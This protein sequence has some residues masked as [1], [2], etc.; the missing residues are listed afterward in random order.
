MRGKSNYSVV[1]RWF[2]QPVDAA[3]LGLFRLS[4]GGFMLLEALTRFPKVTGV[5]SPT[6]FH[7]KYPL[8]TWVQGFPEHWM[9]YAEIAV[10][11][12]AALGI[13]LGVFFRASSLLFGSIYFHLFLT[14]TVYYNNHFYLTSIVTVLL[15]FTGADKTFS[16]S[17]FRSRDGEGF[18]LPQTVPFWNYILIR[19]QFF[20]L[21]FFGGIAKLNADWIRAEPIKYWFQTSSSVRPPL[22]WVIREEWFA[23]MAAYGGIAI[24]LGAP[25][26]LLWRRTR[27][28]AIAVLVGFHLM[29]SRIFKIGFFPFLGIVAC[30]PFLHP[31]TGRWIWSKYQKFIAGVSRVRSPDLDAA[32]TNS[33]RSR[34]AFWMVASFL[35][36]QMIFPLRAYI[37]GQNPAWTEVGHKF[38]WRMML[39]NKD[40]YIKFKFSHPEAETWLNEHP[41]LRPKLAPEHVNG[42]SKHPWMILQYARELDSVLAENG[43]TD[44]KIKVLSVVSLN[45]RP[46]RVLID[47]TADLTEID[48]P[49]WG[50]PKWIVPLDATPLGEKRPMTKEGRM[51]SIVEA[52]ELYAEEHPGNISKDEILEGVGVQ[53]R[54]A[55]PSVEK[56]SQVIIKD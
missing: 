22:T 15:A 19:G 7:F 9:I 35:L 2:Y 26:L 27:P 34:V 53:S 24:D 5:Y 18:A 55:A 20:I 12:L 10:L 31:A 38:S 37:F 17:S 43:M 39:R 32:Q 13:F 44:T 29:N 21:Y 4:W 50:V 11:S 16:F 42:M 46:Y 48:Y 40:A 25:F 56:P 6:Y 30:I 28:Y 8:F 14:D 33:R 41:D 49:L 1:A 54:K 47:P 51:K 52:L 23:W 3:T 36:F 45:D